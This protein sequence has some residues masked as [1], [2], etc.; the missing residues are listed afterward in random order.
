V[1][2]PLP[3]GTYQ[4]YAE[5]TSETGLSETLTA[6][7]ALPA[8]SG[9]ALPPM[10]DWKMVNE[11]WCQSPTVPVENAAQP[12]AL[13]ADDAWHFGPE[14]AFA[15]TRTQVSSLMDGS[16]MV[17]ENAGDLVE[18]RE[19]ALRFTVFTAD[20]RK[21]A[22]QPYMGMLGHAVVRRSDGAVF[23]HLHPAGTISMAAQELLTPR[24]RAQARTLATPVVAGEEVAFPYAFPR[25][26]E[27]RVWTQV[28]IGGR[29]LTGDFSVRVK[30]AR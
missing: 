14:P 19:T 28:R 25:A 12:F 7:V 24:D 2:P 11:V 16:K 17:F 3:A 29:V 6:R 30:A 4:L 10:A 27:Y 21:A 5:V 13:D 22:L 23:A 8:P 26:G 9:P 15:E 1:L 20:G 18:N